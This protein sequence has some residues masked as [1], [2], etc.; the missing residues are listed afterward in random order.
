MLPIPAPILYFWHSLENRIL[1]TLCNIAAD[2]NLT[3]METCYKV[4]RTQMAQSIPIT[5][6]RQLNRFSY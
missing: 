6:E 4:F 1:T 2:V 3:D 5:S